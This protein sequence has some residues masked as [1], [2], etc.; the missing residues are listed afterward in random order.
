[1]IGYKRKRVAKAKHDAARKVS[2]HWRQHTINIRRNAVKDSQLPRVDIVIVYG[3]NKYAAE[4]DFVSL[5]D[6]TVCKTDA[7][8]LKSPL[9]TG[10]IF[11]GERQNLTGAL[12]VAASQLT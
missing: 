12:A 6:T 3:L 2:S 1:M 11:I 10:P 8:K 7:E 4:S 5:R 9:D